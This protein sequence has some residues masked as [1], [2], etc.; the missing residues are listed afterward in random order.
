MTKRTS[1]NLTEERQRLLDEASAIVAR[2]DVDDPPM[3]DVI[4]AALTHL[5]ESHQNLEDAR[6]D[7]PLEHI[8]AVGNTSVLA[9]HYRTSVDQRWR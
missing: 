7:V 5:V 4:D 3:S 1:L 8:Q 9:L 2:D 6:D